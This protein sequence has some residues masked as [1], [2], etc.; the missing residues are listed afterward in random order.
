MDELTHRSSLANTGAS[1]FVPRTVRT[2]DRGFLFRLFG[3]LEKEEIPEEECRLAVRSSSGCGGGGGG[4]GEGYGG[5]GGEGI[6]G[7]EPSGGESIANS[8][9]EVPEP[10]TVTITANRP[11]DPIAAPA[12]P[13]QVAAWDINLNGQSILVCFVLPAPGKALIMKGG[14]RRLSLFRAALHYYSAAKYP[15]ILPEMLKLTCTLTQATL[16]AQVLLA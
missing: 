9:P 1:Q 2:Q 11:A 5:G 15:F 16:Q 6:G 3:R 7:W 10:Q 13:V 4:G 14:L 12:E 8:R